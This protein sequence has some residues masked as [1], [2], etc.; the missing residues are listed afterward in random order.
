MQRCYGSA[1]QASDQRKMQVIDMEVQYVE[2]IRD[3]HELVQHDHVV[4]NGVV[5]FGLEPQRRPAARYEVCVR[6][7]IAA[8][9]QG[10]VVTEGDELFGQ[11]GDDA[12]GSTV[13]PRGHTLH[14]GRNLRDSHSTFRDFG[15]GATVAWNDKTAASVKFQTRQIVASREYFVD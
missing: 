9:E 1:L 12:L 11:I 3:P 4:G 13:E 5:S 10:D 14:Q 6:H 2:L 7:G 15:V 8:G